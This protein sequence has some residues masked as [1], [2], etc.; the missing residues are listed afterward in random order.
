M[1]EQAVL[2]KLSRETYAHLRDNAERSQRSVEDVLSTVVA[3][4]SAQLPEDLD[5][6][7][8]TMAAYTDDQLWH[9]VSMRL[10][11]PDEK[12]LDNLIATSKL[13]SLTQQEET[14]LDMLLKRFYRLI[15]LRSEAL[16]QLKLRGYDMDNYLNL[17]E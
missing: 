13:T 10:N 5:E 2:V 3:L 15:L 8:D 14:E 4:F 9:V 6:I 7:L 17:S 11:L 1:S 12:R 16:L